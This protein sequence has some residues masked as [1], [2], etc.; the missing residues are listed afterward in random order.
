MAVMPVSVPD[1]DRILIRHPDV[2]VGV[3]G[4]RAYPEAIM[5]QLLIKTRFPGSEQPNL[6]FELPHLLGPGDFEFGAELRDTTGAWRPT[7]VHFAGGGGGGEPG[8]E[9]NFEFTFWVPLPDGTQG[10]KLWCSWGAHGVAKTGAQ[11]DVDRI[12]DASL[13]SR[14][15][16]STR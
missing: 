10:L 11:L 8:G 7:T 5:L 4:V 2:F 15:V 16:W 12:T 13:K 14:S 1:Q 3:T 6:A 9:G